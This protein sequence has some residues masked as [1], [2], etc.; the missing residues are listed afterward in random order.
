MVT[1]PWT[2]NHNEVSL[3]F[4]TWARYKLHSAHEWAALV[5]SDGIVHL[6]VDQEPHTVSMLHQLRCINL[7]REQLTQSKAGR[8]VD[9]TQHCM[10]YL[11]QMLMCHADDMLDPYQY[12]HK[13]NALNAQPVRRCRDW[14]AVYERVE[15]NQR[16][17]SL[18]TRAGL[19]GTERT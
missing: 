5:P 2:I 11:R 12:V 9:R 10:N 17:H 19:N 6:G 7:M 1:V 3:Q 15:D 14:R 4:D 13:M 8:D 18:R 16:E